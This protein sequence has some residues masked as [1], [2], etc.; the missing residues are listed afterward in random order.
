MS[1]RACISAR[2]L[3]AEGFDYDMRRQGTFE[4]VSDGD[5]PMRFIGGPPAT[6][7]G[8]ELSAPIPGTNRSDGVIVGGS[9]GLDKN[10]PVLFLALPE[11]RISLSKTLCLVR[12]NV[13]VFTASLK[14]VEAPAPGRKHIRLSER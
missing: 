12:E 3:A 11:D 1:P 5:M 4:S 7:R 8:M 9:M 14:D 2:S 13:E 6:P 10:G